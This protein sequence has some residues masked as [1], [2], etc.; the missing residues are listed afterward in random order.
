MSCPRSDSSN[1]E[2]CFIDPFKQN[3]TKNLKSNKNITKINP[4]KKKKERERN[5]L[6]GRCGDFGMRSEVEVFREVY[7]DDSLCH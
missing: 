7:E 5:K 4:K 6:A 2:S 1:G 3:K